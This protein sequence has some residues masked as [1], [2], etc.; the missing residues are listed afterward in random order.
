M[1]CKNSNKLFYVEGA[2]VDNENHFLS[3]FVMYHVVILIPNPAL[4]MAQNAKSFE[5][6]TFASIIKSFFDQRALIKECGIQ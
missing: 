4:T 3:H 1:S 5:K 2:D 6:K